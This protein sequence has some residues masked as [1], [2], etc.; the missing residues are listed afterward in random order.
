ML[1][2]R[3]LNDYDIISNPLVNGIASKQMIFEIVS[4][5]YENNTKYRNLSKEEK[6]KIIEENIESYLEEHNKKLEKKFIK[7]SNQSR[8]DVKAYLEFYKSFKSKGLDEKLELIKNNDQDINFGSYIHFIKHLST[9]QSHLLYGSTK[10]TDWISTSTKLS[11]IM[12][13]YDKQKVHQV[14]VIKSDT[15]G[16]LDSNNTLSV[17]LSTFEGIEKKNT[18]LCNKIDIDNENIDFLAEL[19]NVSPITMFNFQMNLINPTNIKARGFNYSTN[20][21]EVCILRYIPKDY[22]ISILEALQIDII[23]CNRFNRSF[24]GHSIKDQETELNR[25]KFLLLE[26]LKEINDPY[27]LFLY[28][29]LYIK[30][31]NINEI[32]SFNQSKSYVEFNK[33]KILKLALQIPSS[34]IKR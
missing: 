32:I 14:A 26:L 22:I 16:I 33:D 27:L 10:V 17:D 34:M 11:K 19:S 12:R 4:S 2:F 30:N 9:L 6:D 5:Y 15:N 18:F 3:T 28:E 21:K 23:K 24:V 1:L 20:S 8:E 7:N 31:K 13:Y 29:E 25:V